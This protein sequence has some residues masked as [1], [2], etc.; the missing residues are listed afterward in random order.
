MLHP[1]SFPLK[2]LS[3][4]LLECFDV[5]GSGL[6]HDLRR[7][8][9]GLAILVPASLRQPIANELLVVRWLS[10]PRLILIRWPEARAIWRQYLIDQNQLI[11]H[12]PEL[13]L[14]IRDDHAPA[15]R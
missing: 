13:K 10:A 5:L 4:K 11:I 8:L 15:A 3:R 2:T 1:H 14:R 7:Q 6:F 12:Q 9:G